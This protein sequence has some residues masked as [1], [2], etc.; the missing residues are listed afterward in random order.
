MLYTEKMSAIDRSRP[1]RQ[2]M[3]TARCGDDGELSVL[4]DKRI[5]VEETEEGDLCV[6]L[7]LH[8]EVSTLSV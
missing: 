8:T 1:G 6:E 4:A 7:T 2:V 3:W 5:P